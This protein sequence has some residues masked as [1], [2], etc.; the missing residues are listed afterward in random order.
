MA[1]C[2]CYTVMRVSIIADFIIIKLG[3]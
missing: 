2:T 3:Y 1:I